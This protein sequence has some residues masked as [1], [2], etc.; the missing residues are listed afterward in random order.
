MPQRVVDLLEI[1]EV[2]TEHRKS[3]AAVGLRKRLFDSLGQQ[4]A[5][6]RFGQRIMARHERDFGF[7]AALLGDVLVG[8]KPAAIRGQL[9]DNRDDAVPTEV[10]E[11]FADPVGQGLLLLGEKV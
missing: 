2:E 3:L 11:I 9:P 8:R 10:L 7:G 4:S 5:V 1:V 6:R